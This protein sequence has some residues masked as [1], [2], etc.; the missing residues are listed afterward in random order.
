V[1]KILKFGCLGI[2]AVVVVLFILVAAFGGSGSRTTITEQP[3]KP[4]AVQSGSEPKAAQS[5]QPQSQQ[6][7]KPAVPSSLPV[8]KVGQRIESAGIALT[9]N[10]AEQKENAGQFLQAKPGRVY[11]VTD[12][13]LENATRDTAPYNPLY[14]KVKDS[15]GFEYNGSL[16]GDDRSLKAG[17]LAT[18]EKARGT[19]AFDVPANAKELVL[20]Y[21]PMVLFGGYQVLRVA[22]D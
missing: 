1:G 9:V 21:Q 19:V 5:P 14:F 22:L 18:G 4:A 17:E 2:I 15:D 6:A 13:T 10:S 3:A 16:I 7:S 12:V 8:A 11:L 20:S